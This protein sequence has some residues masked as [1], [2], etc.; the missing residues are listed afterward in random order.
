MWTG[1]QLLLRPSKRTQSDVGCIMPTGG[2]LL[3]GTFAPFFTNV[4]DDLAETVTAS[5]IFEMKV[6]RASLT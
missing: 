6:L 3:P 5:F 2:V 4:I 1:K